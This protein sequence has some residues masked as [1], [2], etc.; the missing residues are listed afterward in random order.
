[1]KIWRRHTT[2][3]R[4]SFCRCSGWRQTDPYSCLPSNVQ[5][6]RSCIR[7][8]ARW[9]F[10]C[11]RRLGRISNVFPHSFFD[12]PWGHK[13]IASS[14]ASPKIWALGNSASFCVSQFQTHR[15]SA[16]PKL[17]FWARFARIILTGIFRSFWFGARLFAVSGGG[18]RLISGDVHNIVSCGDNCDAFRS[19]VSWKPWF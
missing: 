3:R 19:G 8:S 17:S 11:P 6:Y 18:V 2:W 5:P 12:K 15:L 7:F 10:A 1:M 13:M 4:L 14:S 16:I 9:T